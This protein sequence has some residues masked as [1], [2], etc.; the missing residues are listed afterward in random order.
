MVLEHT[1]SEEIDHSPLSAVRKYNFKNIILCYYFVCIF[2]IAEFKYTFKD[3]I[4]IL[5][6]DALYITIEMP[7]K[8]I[9]I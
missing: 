3:C 6:A 5:Y 4:E 9:I 8:P 7:L 1:L 2:L